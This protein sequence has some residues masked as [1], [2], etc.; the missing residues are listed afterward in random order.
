MKRLG[1]IAIVAGAFVVILTAAIWIY[2]VR[3][4]AI[5]GAILCDLVTRDQFLSRIYVAFALVV[6][7]GLLAIADGIGQLRSGAP[8]W[9]LKVSI[10]ALFIVACVVGASGATACNPP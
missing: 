8:N 6:V 3:Q 9:M 2:M 5:P 1:W 10:F 4:S 7:C